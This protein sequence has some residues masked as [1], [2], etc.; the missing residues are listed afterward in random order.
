MQKGRKSDVPAKVESEYYLV[1]ASNKYYQGDLVAAHGLLAKSISIDSNC[2]ACYYLLANVLL[3]A[4]YVH[5][6]LSMSKMAF[7]LD[8]TNFWY[9][10]Q[11]AKVSELDGNIDLAIKTY[12]YLL[13][14]DDKKD[15][16]IFYNLGSLYCLKQQFD[17]A[18]IVYDSAQKVY[19]YSDR[20][21]F[22]RQQLYYATKNNS[23]AM[24]EALR[25]YERDRESPQ[26]N[27]LLGEIFGRSGNNEEALKYLERAHEIDESYAAPLFGLA[28]IYRESYEYDKFFDIVNKIAINESIPLS[29][30]IDY[31]APVLQF[32]GQVTYKEKVE[33]LFPLLEQK[34]AN[35]WRFKQFYAT[36][37]IQTLRREE[38]LNIIDKALQENKRNKD[39]W[40]MKIALMYYDKDWENLLQN[41][42]TALLYVSKKDQRDFLLQKTTAFYELKRYKDAILVL[43]NALKEGKIDANDK[44]IYAFLGDLYHTE[45]NRKM[46]Y[47]AYDKA[48]E[49]DA[50]NIGVLNNYAYYLS[51]ENK[52]L[53][54]ALEMSKKTIDAEPDN[55]TFLDTYAWILHKLGRNE[56]AKPIFRRAM[57][58]GGRESAVILDHYGDVLFE[59]KE[60]DTAILYWEDALSKKDVTNAENIR[61]KIE[62]CKEIKTKK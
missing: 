9:G 47:K 39:A 60:Y 46:S 30:K 36:F 17:T 40:G 13:E 8:S 26:A 37:L 55:A 12:K 20:L 48:L 62:K 42:D 50:E 16:D 25:Y 59:L 56:E 35:D 4:G 49:I 1:N 51:E 57:T 19:G 23:A 2:D 45:G 44:D 22:A 54:R 3:K 15:E 29:D 14:F 58:S 52:D 27:V 33:N 61:K 41:V 7:K 10:K 34:H 53:K 18:L 43:E 32:W 21:V 38:G 11:L 28:E 5:D 6:A 31:F 24:V